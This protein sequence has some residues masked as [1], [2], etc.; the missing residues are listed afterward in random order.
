MGYRQRPLPVC[1]L[2]PTIEGQSGRFSQRPMRQAD[3]DRMICR[4][5]AAAG[6]ETRVTSIGRG[7]ESVGQPA[8]DEQNLRVHPPTVCNRVTTACLDI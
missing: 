7:I 4:R 3:V 1:H 6:M 5:E 8:I 2:F